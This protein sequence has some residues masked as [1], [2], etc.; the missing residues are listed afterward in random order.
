MDTN[1]IGWAVGGGDIR[2]A[3]VAGANL[4]LMEHQRIPSVLRA[5]S[6][7]ALNASYIVSKVGELKR[8]YPSAELDWAEDIGRPLWDF[9]LTEI[10]KPDDIFKKKPAL[11]LAYQLIAKK[12]DGF[13]DTAPLRKLLNKNV[14]S[15]NISASG[16]GLGVGAVNYSDGEIHYTES[17]ATDFVNYIMASAAIPIA[18]PVEHIG[19]QP[20]IDGGIRDSVP[21]GELIKENT[22]EIIC[23]TPNPERLGSVEI[24][25]GDILQCI[26]RIIDI[27]LNNNL[28]NDL[29]IARQTNALLS[30]KEQGASYD[31][32]TEEWLKGKRHVKMDIVIRPETQINVSISDFNSSDIEGMLWSGY[33]TA[34]KLLTEHEQK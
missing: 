17:T 6:A 1:T 20:F 13:T 23:I 8:K 11:V 12:F 25:T 10:R 34:D 18:M 3:W 26:G 21:L 15:E 30:G 7:G 2:G 22:D 32:Q 27:F 16:L 19:N 24:D 33:N 29:K 5:I 4:A 9:W 31:E 28:N 14:N